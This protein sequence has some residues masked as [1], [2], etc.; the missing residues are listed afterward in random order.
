M[1]SE[2]KNTEF[3]CLADNFCKEFVLYQEKYMIE[4]Q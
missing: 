3:Y 1:F 2:S 4:D